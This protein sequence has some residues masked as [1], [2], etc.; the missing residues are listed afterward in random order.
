ME[1]YSK[2]MADPECALIAVGFQN[3]CSLHYSRMQNPEAIFSPC[4]EK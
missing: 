1:L 4:F 2:H 3:P